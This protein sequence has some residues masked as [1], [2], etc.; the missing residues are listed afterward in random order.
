MTR[1][2]KTQKIEELTQ[3]LNDASTLYLADVSEI[4]AAVT[5]D[6]RRACFKKDVRL[7]VVKNKLLKIA[8]ERSEKE[9]NDLVDT[10]EGP[11][12]VMFSETGN[13]PAKLIKEFRKKSERPLLKGAYIEQETYIGDDQLEA[14]A[15]IKSKEELLADVIAL[16]QAPAKNV[17]SAL[18]S[19]QNT[20]TGV[21]ETLS[22]RSEE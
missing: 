1:E 12:A 17:V 9:F 4:N 2:E 15:N 11:T 8:M 21:L 18:Q 7:A 10:L 14:L 16:L 3:E 22:E 19:G 13:V 6:L 5:S 20:L